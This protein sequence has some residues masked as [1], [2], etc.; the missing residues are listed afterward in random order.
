MV[1]LL[2]TIIMAIV[3]G[4]IGSAIAPGAMPGGIIGSMIA[5]FAG[6]WLGALLL[7]SWGP[8]IGG[9]AVIPAIVG[10]ALFIFLIGLLAK[11]FRG[12]AT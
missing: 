10:A 5:G 12:R 3:I 8:V 4:A 2:I 1:S 6:A 11:A 7:G 9:F